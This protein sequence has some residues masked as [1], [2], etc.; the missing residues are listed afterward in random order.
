[1]FLFLSQYS[2]KTFSMKPYNTNSFSDFWAKFLKALMGTHT[3]N[4]NVIHY[5][6]V[7]L[8]LAHST[9]VKTFF[10]EFKN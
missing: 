7:L 6:I 8:T 4:L 10:S 3:Y 5:F 1:M 9:S 2:I